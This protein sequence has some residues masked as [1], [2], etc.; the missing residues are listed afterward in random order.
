MPKAFRSP[1]RSSI[2]PTRASSARRSSVM[3]HVEGRVFWEAE[4]P[5]SNPAERAQVYD[6]MNATLARLHSFD[7]AAIGLCRLR[8]R[9]KLCG[10]PDR[11][12]VEAI[13][14]LGNGKDRGYGAADGVAAGAPAAAAA[15]A[16]GARRLSAR[17]HDPRAA[18]P[19]RYWP[20][21]TGSC[22]RLAIRWPISPIT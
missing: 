16:A 13:P 18:T 6:A 9:R 1:S 19:R 17:Q 14:R 15:A 21:S 2:A 7:P 5:S 22:R 11:A 4:M 10:S 8:P 12:L 3:S 20:C